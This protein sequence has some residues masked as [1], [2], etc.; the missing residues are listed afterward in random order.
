M[1][2]SLPPAIQLA[3]FRQADAVPI[4]GGI[5]A[6]TF[7]VA[8]LTGVLFSLAPMLGAA[9]IHAGAV[10]MMAGDRGG[11]GRLRMVRHG[12]VA[13]EVALAVVVLFGAGLMIKSVA[14]LLSV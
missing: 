2:E 13:A 1:A 11:T 5:L 8:L 9:R 12:L 7:T 6:F 4:D 14:R 3:P 10:L